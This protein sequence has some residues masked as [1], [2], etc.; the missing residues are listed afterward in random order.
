MKKYSVGLFLTLLIPSF[1]MAQWV[2]FYKS[3]NETSF[4]LES[5]TTLTKDNFVFSGIL[6]N[7]SQ[8]QSIKN[9]KGALTNYQSVSSTFMYNCQSK[10]YTIVDSIYYSNA[11]AKGASFSLAPEAPNK[12]KWLTPKKD[13]LSQNLSGK[14]KS[15]CK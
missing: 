6:T 8:P 14:I 11:N 9:E 1:A 4:F 10:Q 13:H 12:V 2:E 7:H 3:D 15:L 5:K